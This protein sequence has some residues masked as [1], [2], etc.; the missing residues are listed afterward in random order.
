MSDLRK[1]FQ[2]FHLLCAGLH[3]MPY[4]RFF[5]LT[6]LPPQPYTIIRRKND[7]TG[8]DS[9]CSGPESPC[10]QPLL[11]LCR[12]SSPG[13]RRRQSFHRMQHRKRLL[14]SDSVRIAVAGSSS[15]CCTPCGACR[16]FLAEFCDDDM[17]VICINKDGIFEAYSLNE[18]LPHAFR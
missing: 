17:E 16:Q 9:T 2:D 4:I 5:L 1:N 11:R 6:A 15:D 8:T 10:L 12:G 3:R 7:T 18:L 14:L 13:M